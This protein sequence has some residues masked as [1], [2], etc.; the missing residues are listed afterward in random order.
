MWET[1]ALGA[2]QAGSQIYSGYK[3]KQAAYKNASLI[4]EDSVFQRRRAYDQASRLRNQGEAFKGSQR[5]AYASAGVKLTEGSPLAVLKK[6]EENLRQDIGRTR[7]SGD[8]AVERGTHQANALEQQ[9]NDAFTAS[10]ISA[11]TS[12]AGTLANNINIPK[13]TASSGNYI[14]GVGKST[15]S[16]MNTNLGLGGY[17]GSYTGMF[18]DILKPKE[19]QYGPRVF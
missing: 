3:Q 11:A 6:T 18:G 13:S 17:N 8:L 2:I 10:L 12:F 1:I 19:N 5:T 4:R 9:G 7:Q 15:D 14:Y 16:W